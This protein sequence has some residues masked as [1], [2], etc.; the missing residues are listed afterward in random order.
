MIGRAA[1]VAV[2][3]ALAATPA[4]AEPVDLGPA[5]LAL[6][7]AWAGPPATPDGVTRTRGDATLIVVRYDVGN[8]PAWR[9]ATRAAHVDAIVRGFAATAGYA[10]LGR[11]LGKTGPAGVPTLDLTFRRRGPHGAEVVAARV[12]LFRTLTMVAIAAAPRDRAAVDAAVR[13]LTP[14]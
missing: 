1:A 3:A 10:E 2:V 14:D 6:D 5:S 12:L 11:T 9:E 13:A 4:A 8:L 7:G